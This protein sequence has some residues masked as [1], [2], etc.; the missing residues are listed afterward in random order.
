MNSNF[1]LK[2]AVTASGSNIFDD[3]S[4]YLAQVEGK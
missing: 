1:G 4:V 2:V 3:I